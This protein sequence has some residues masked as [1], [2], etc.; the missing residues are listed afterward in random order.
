MGMRNLMATVHKIRELSKQKPSLKRRFLKEENLM[1]FVSLVLA[2][3]LIL[4]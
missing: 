2:T 3:I 1:E 4:L